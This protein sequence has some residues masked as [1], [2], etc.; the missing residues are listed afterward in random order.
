MWCFHLA[1][2]SID[3]NVVMLLGLTRFHILHFDNCNARGFRNRGFY[4]VPLVDLMDVV[5]NL[6]IALCLL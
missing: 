3:V 6:H 2:A 4:V 5:W 1:I